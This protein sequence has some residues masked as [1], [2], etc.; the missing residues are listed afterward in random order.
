MSTMP[1]WIIPCP[2]LAF[3]PPLLHSP[4]FRVFLVSSIAAMSMSVDKATA[5][6]SS[7]DLAIVW[8][9]TAI[10]SFANDLTDRGLST[11]IPRSV[12]GL[13]TDI[14]GSEMD[15]G[16]STEALAMVSVAGAEGRPSWR[17]VPPDGWDGRCSELSAASKRNWF[18][19]LGSL[20]V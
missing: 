7:A 1:C 20:V 9:S 13:S 2:R 8:E 5:I 17:S 11:D 15:V 3:P 12:M 18:A 10:D 14:P 6:D 16:W 4:S 19:T